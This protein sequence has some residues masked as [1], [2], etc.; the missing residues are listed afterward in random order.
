MEKKYNKIHII[1]SQGIGLSALAGLLSAAGARISGSDLETGGHGAAN[2]PLDADLIIYS[3]AVPSDNPERDRARELKIPESSYPQALGE[4]ARGKKV[5][6]VSGTNGK[7]TTTAMIGWIMEKAGFDPTVIVGSSV[8][9][10]NKNYRAGK[11]DWIVLEAD[12]YKRAFLNYVPDIAV[13]TN[14]A[15]DHLD[16]YRD[17]DDIKQAFTEFITKLKPSG[18]LVYNLE[19]ENTVAVSSDPSPGDGEGQRER[20]LIGFVHGNFKLRVPGQF[21]QQ[22]AAA[23]SAVCRVLGI[24]Q[25][26][27]EGA[28]ATFRGTWRRF[29]R[30]GRLGSTEIISDYAHHPDGVRAV[31]A[32]ANEI[33]GGKTLAVFQP[34]QHNRTKKLFAQFVEAFSASPVNDIIISEIFD[35]AGREQ[36]ADQDVSSK[37]LVREIK[38]CGKHVIYANNLQDCETMTR[39]LAKDYNAIIIMGAGDIYK[40]ADKLVNT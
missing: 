1:G 9:D 23:A 20:S 8:L 28:L 16:Y 4:F 36:T 2:V 19:D 37:D 24:S 29:E 3:N 39:E 25:K 18:I 22:N 21:N 35:V 15:L 27:I 32:A 10:W 40:V 11:G 30:V 14:I 17:L 34:H 12:E 6:A 7:T 31:L 5:I 13:I 33:Y 26:T 38:K